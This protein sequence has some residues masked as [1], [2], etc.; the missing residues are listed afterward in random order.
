[1]VKVDRTVNED[2][3]VELARAYAM[4]HEGKFFGKKIIQIL[5]EDLNKAAGFEFI[6]FNRV[7][8]TENV[9]SS[10][11]FVDYNQG[12]RNPDRLFTIILVGN[13]VIKSIVVDGPKLQ[14]AYEAVA[15][16]KAQE[17]IV[18]EQERMASEALQAAQREERLKEYKPF[19]EI[20]KDMQ[21]GDRAV[22]WVE[23]S[24][25]VDV[26]FYREHNDYKYYQNGVHGPLKLSSVFVNGLYKLEPRLY[27]AYRA[28]EALEDGHTVRFYKEGSSSPH[29]EISPED[30][31]SGLAN[32]LGGIQVKELLAERWS[33]VYKAE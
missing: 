21:H 16:S 24:S 17:A 33:I 29:V 30:Y 2:N 3:V 10:R 25:R 19:H 15:K 28:V 4:S 26:G 12:H 1:M 11:A 27:S 9:S 23:D 14:W 8:I 7:E 5:I 32:H 22:K 13:K 20:I 18:A 6:D 31:L